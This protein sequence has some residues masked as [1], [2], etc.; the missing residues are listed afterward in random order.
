MPGVFIAVG[1]A[2]VSFSSTV[3]AHAAFSESF[4]PPTVGIISELVSPGDGLGLAVAEAERSHT[5]LGG[6]G[7]RGR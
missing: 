5:Q 6:L 1:F 2:V 4:A 7:E 3:F